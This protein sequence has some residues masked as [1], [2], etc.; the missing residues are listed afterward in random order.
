M[1]LLVGDF[2]QKELR[3]L[4]AVRPGGLGRVGDVLDD[5]A[6]FA[7]QIFVQRANHFL[8]VHLCLLVHSRVC[9]MRATKIAANY[10]PTLEPD[11]ARGDSTELAE[12]K[13]GR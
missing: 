7:G 10:M 8:L 9:E 12:V 3:K 13:P 2:L 5:G 1:A 6:Q 11:N 4:R